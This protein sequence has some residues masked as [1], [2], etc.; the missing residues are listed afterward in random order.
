MAHEKLAMQSILEQEAL[1]GKKSVQTP[2]K[3]SPVK[4]E[5]LEGSNSTE[6]D[7][8]PFTKEQQDHLLNFIYDNQNMMRIYCL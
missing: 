8:V 4:G 7:N 2:L 3:K 5:N 6:S 1:W